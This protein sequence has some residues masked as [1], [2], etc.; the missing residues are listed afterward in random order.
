[1]AIWNLGSINADYVYSVPHIPAPGETLASTERQ[2]YL[3]GKGANMS[4]AAA[5]AGSLVHHIGAIGKDGHWAVDRLRESSISTDHV[6][7]LD[8]ATGQAIIAVDDAGENA[9]IL[10]SGANFEIT[11]SQVADAL[12]RASSGDWFVCQNETNQQA[13]AVKLAASL[14]M[15]VAYAAAPFDAEAVASVLAHLDF[16]ILNEIEM[17]QLTEATGKKANELGI[18]TV[19]V[20][21]GSEGADLYSAENGSEKI[22]FDAVK[23]TPV[24][25]TGAGDTFTGYVLS[26]LDR[27]LSVHEAVETANYAG[28]LM[29]TRRGTADV[30]P[31]IEEVEAFRA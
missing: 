26:G 24:D 19:I 2:V 20:T 17:F 30:I 7:E 21:L 10:H 18:D 25:T 23:V 12:G 9:I 29:V 8:V 5:R 16:I 14:A 13:N 28:A 6:A 15:K 31:T 11:E 27:G 3:G 1:M 4:V 22:H